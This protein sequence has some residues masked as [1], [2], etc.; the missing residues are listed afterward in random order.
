VRDTDGSWEQPRANQP[1]APFGNRRLGAMP[2]RLIG[3]V[4]VA[5]VTACF[6]A[7]DEPEMGRS[8]ARECHRRAGVGSHTDLTSV[9]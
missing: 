2:A 6:A 9:V 1:R 3:W 8:G 7:H 5:P 4:E